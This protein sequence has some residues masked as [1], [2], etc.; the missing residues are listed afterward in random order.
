MK[1]CDIFIPGPGSPKENLETSRK[2]PCRSIGNSSLKN[3]DVIPEEISNGTPAGIKDGV[4][5]KINE[6]ISDDMSEEIP[7]G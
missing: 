5:G 1:F 2:N 4:P 7:K 6:E 3:S